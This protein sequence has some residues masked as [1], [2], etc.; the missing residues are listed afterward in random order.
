MKMLAISLAVGTAVNLLIDGGTTFAA[1]HTLSIQ[2]WLIL[3]GLAI[4]CTAVGYSVWFM[5][6]R[7]C[8]V[9]V[10]ALTVFAQSIFGVGLAAFWLREPLR[11]GQF[12]GCLSIVGG[13]VLGL[14]RQVNLRSRP[15]EIANRKS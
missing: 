7:E 6:I 4:I 8:P 10:A 12:F 3:L 13:L 5:I 14:S 1:V 9:N 2:S 15:V 11:W